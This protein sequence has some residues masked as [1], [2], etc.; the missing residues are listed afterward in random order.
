MEKWININQTYIINR[1]MGLSS[2]QKAFFFQR[3]YRFW[4][5]LVVNVVVTF[6]HVKLS[7]NVI[8][9][10]FFNHTMNRLFHQYVQSVPGIV[11]AF[12]V[13]STWSVLCYCINNRLVL[14]K[15]THTQKKR[16]YYF[17]NFKLKPFE[18][19][20]IVLNYQIQCCQWFFHQ[21]QWFTM[22][23]DK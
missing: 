5:D 22:M 8:F 7:F 19:Q 17:R 11:L 15:I 12:R 13:R 4:F 2:A 10:F 3:K 20:S 23:G 6:N 16:Y 9:L 14:N 1:L 21:S 18:Q